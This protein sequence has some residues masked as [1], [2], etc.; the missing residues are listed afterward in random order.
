MEAVA[1]LMCQE[2]NIKK[3]TPLVI[4]R[5]ILMSWEQKS[6]H[7]S[8]PWQNAQKLSAV[9][10]G[11]NE[12]P[13]QQQQQQ[14]GEGSCHAPD[15]FHFSFPPSLFISSLKTIRSG[16][17]CVIRAQDGLQRLQETR[18][19]DYSTLLLSQSNTSFLSSPIRS[20]SSTNHSTNPASRR[21]ESLN[22]NIRSRW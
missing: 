4:R 1:Q 6:G 12:P 22:S 20:S 16:H 17:L 5:A 10:R 3:I 14:Q 9:K 8:Q 13:F 15:I 7:K 19:L 18:L 11:P 2:S 21:M